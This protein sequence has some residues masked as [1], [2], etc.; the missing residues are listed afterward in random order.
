MAIHDTDGDG[1]YDK[2][3]NEIFDTNPEIRDT[4]GDE[5]P[6]GSED[7]DGDGISNLEYQDENL[8]EYD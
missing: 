4:D 1:L 2:Y 7:H 8:S 6:D 5:I 3:K